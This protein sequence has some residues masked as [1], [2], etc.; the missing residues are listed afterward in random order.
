MFVPPYHLA[1][2]HAGL[3]NVDAAFREIRRACDARDPW[4]D[5]LPIE[6]RFEILRGD[7]RYS[8]VLGRLKLTRPVSQA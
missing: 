3:G 7:P 1:L 4:L 6:P 2:L 5:T 8:D